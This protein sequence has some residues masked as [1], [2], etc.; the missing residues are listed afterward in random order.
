MVGA[1]LIEYLL[2][3]TRVSGPLDGGRNFHIFYY[4]LEGSTHEERVQWHLSDVAHFNYLTGS[5]IVGYY[6]FAKIRF[7][8]GKGGYLEII[9]GHLKSLGIG[10]R[11]QN[12]IWQL[13]AAVLHLG[14]IQFKEPVAGETCTIKNFQQLQLVSEMLGILPDSL[15]TA[16]TSRTR[17]VG[18]DN[19][20][21]YFNEKEAIVQ[22][23]SLARNLYATCF[24][25][26]VE[27]INQK[28]C[29]SDADFNRFVS[30]LEVPGFAGTSGTRNDFNRLLVNFANE[31][32]YSHTMYEL[33]VAQE[34][35][36]PENSYSSNQEI[37]NVLCSE[38]KGILRLIDHEAVARTSDEA[39]TAKIYEQFL[40]TGVL[41]SANSKKLSTAFGIHHF[42]G[43]VE[44]DT[45]G[46]GEFERDVLQSDYVTLIRGDPESPGTNNPFLRS[47][48][49]DRIIATRKAKDST[50]LSATPRGRVPSLRRR[51]SKR[52]IEDENETLDATST[53][54]H[55]VTILDLIIVS[56]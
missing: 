15:E 5:T 49:S 43:V 25:W 18:K 46:F 1:K 36:F 4:L 51:P 16:L 44:Y 7:A 39:V 9:K 10:R 17:V 52:N 26:I 40:E 47:L 56:Y 13:L 35:A 19:V 11:Q 21:E 27:Q 6:F 50:V 8:Q 28:L 32:L 30:I 2:E 54:G 23:D 33:F 34:I 45:I 3:K 53:I 31:K 12:Q 41:I 48:F 22:R 55:M 42:A 29:A 24:S 20:V 38:K 37:L 14:N